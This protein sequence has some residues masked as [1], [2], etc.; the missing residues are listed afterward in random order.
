MWTPKVAESQNFLRRDRSYFISPN[1]SKAHPISCLHDILQ[2]ETHGL[3][4]AKV[5]NAWVSIAWVPCQVESVFV[6]RS[7]DHLS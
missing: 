2:V 1:R 5:L 3:L 7:C 6:R 4:I